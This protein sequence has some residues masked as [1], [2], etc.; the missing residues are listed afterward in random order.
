MLSS[1]CL[2]QIC[3]YPEVSLCLLLLCVLNFSSRPATTPTI[4][5]HVIV[6]QDEVGV[7]LSMP[8]YDQLLGRDTLALTV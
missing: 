8:C 5:Q 3:G 6:I 4:H 1:T 7:P 2:C